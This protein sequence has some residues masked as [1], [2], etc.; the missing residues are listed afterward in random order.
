[1]NRLYAIECTP[2]LTGA[3]ADHRLRCPGARRQAL[4]PGDRPRFE[5]RWRAAR[6]LRSDGEAR[7]L[8]LGAGARPREPS[9]PKPDCRRRRAA[10]SGS[11]AGACH[12][13]RAGKHWPDRV[14]SPVFR[15]GSLQ[16]DRFA[17]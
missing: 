12:E 10:A 8:D 9:R 14:V 15:A 6:P 13:P 2:S 3:M 11:R 1:M 17:V 4:C 16:P 5:D 7:F